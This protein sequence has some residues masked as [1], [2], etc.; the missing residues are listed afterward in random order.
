[1][2]NVY[3]QKFLKNSIELLRSL[4]PVMLQTF[5]TQEHL[6][7]RRAL[8]GT[9]ALKKTLERL[10]G[11]TKELKVHL[12][13]RKLDQSRDLSNWVFEA[14]EALYLADSVHMFG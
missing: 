11:T 12:G 13:T 1:M 14:L 2:Q 5:F 7:L 9:R 3:S 8:G 4:F 6:G 10:L